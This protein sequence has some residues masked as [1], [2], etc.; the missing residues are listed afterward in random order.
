MWREYATAH[1]AAAAQGPEYTVETF[2]DHGDL[3]DQLLALV[4]AGGKRATAQLAS[5]YAAGGDPL[6]R[7]GSHWIA[8]DGTGEPRIIIRTTWLSLASFWSVEQDFAAAEGEDDLTLE[9]WRREH[10]IYFERTCA[11]RGAQWSE[12]EDIV[13]ERFTVVWPPQLADRS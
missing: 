11:A 13:L 12:D 4:I 3:A 10:R 5:E 9:S 2:G 8:C 7:I 6:P 1:P